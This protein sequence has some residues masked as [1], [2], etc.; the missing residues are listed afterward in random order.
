M[1]GV[2]IRP[3]EGTMEQRHDIVGKPDP[4]TETRAVLWTEEG[5]SRKEVIPVNSPA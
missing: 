5:L 3:I 2:Q 4:K 1:I